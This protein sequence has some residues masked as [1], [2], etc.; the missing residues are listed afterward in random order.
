MKKIYL[1]AIAVL[2]AMIGFTSC[3]EDNGNVWSDEDAVTRSMK[4]LTNDY[5]MLDNGLFNLIYPKGWEYDFKEEDPAKITIL[6]GEEITMEIAIFPFGI[7]KSLIEELVKDQINL[8]GATLI[9]RPVT[10]DGL[11]GVVYTA[12]GDKSNKFYCFRNG[13][14]TVVIIMKQSTE[15]STDFR[16]EDNLR[17][18][19]G[20][21][22]QTDWLDEMKDLAIIINDQFQREGYDFDFIKLV[23]EESLLIIQSENYRK[24]VYRDYAKETMSRFINALQ[25]LRNCAEHNYTFRFDTVNKEG[26]ISFSFTFTPD[27]YHIE[28]DVVIM[29]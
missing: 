13:H 14:T 18:K 28:Q 29:E 10:I 3:A 8:D 22:T 24:E 4:E 2:T 6:S 1:M 16:L 17:W 27:D 9:H 7:L 11:E 23:P 12:E 15:E 25:A 21:N 19:K 20:S 5:S 26:E